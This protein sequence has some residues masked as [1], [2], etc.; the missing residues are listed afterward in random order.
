[1]EI[2]TYVLE[3]AL[4][5]RDS[6]GN[7]GIIQPSEL[8]RMSAGTGV[9]HSE[10]NHSQSEPVHLLQIWIVPA[11]NSLPPSYQQKKLAAA[12][13]GS[14]Q[15]I[16]AA[17]A[18]DGAVKIHQDVKLYRATVHDNRVQHRL[19]KERRAYLQVVRGEIVLNGTQLGQGDGAMIV[20]EEEI[21]MALRE[22]A[23]QKFCFL[24]LHNSGTK[25]NVRQQGIGFAGSIQKDRRRARPRRIAQQKA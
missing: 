19:A 22:G 16:A 14:L 11:R 5:H 12:T 17:D 13:P 21:R 7:H 1:M 9:S 20:E 25:M 23:Q 4:E 10:P 18:N 15:L 2:I 6:M 3:G 24:I 8:Q